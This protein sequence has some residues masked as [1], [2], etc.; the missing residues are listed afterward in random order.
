MTSKHKLQSSIYLIKR[1]YAM[2]NP[3]IGVQSAPKAIPVAQPA[4]PPVPKAI[5]VNLA[6]PVPK[7]IPVAQAQPAAPPPAPASP[8]AYV[9]P[10]LSLIRKAE[11]NVA[12]YDTLVGSNRKHGLTG[13]TLQQVMEL[14]KKHK[15]GSAAGAYQII[16]PT[17]KGLI[18]RMK[19]D[20]SKTKYDQATQDLMAMELLKQR[21]FDKYLSG[22]LPLEKARVNIA[23]EWAGLPAYGNTS[24][25]KGV[26]NNQARV[27]EQEYI[28]ALNRARQLYM[29]QNNVA[30]NSSIP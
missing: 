1:A 14:Q 8:N 29:Q 18:S 7:A 20:P 5:P 21:G 17:M 13:L 12:G 23:K 27:T 15:P 9:Q 3:N 19:L 4:P 10:L 16:N 2:Y 26:G 11:S 22:Q 6:Q 30:E 28:D 25:Y 24:Y